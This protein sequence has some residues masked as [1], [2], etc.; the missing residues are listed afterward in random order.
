ML[1]TTH[2]Y[3][4]IE[5]G[6]GLLEVANGSFGDR[7]ALVFGK[8]GSG[9]I[10]EPTKPERVLLPEETLAVV[11]FGNIKSLDIVMSHLR[12]LREKMTKHEELLDGQR[13]EFK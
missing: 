13:S 3:P 11:T 8:N 2:T 4:L 9:V 7:Y 6:H 5:L 10:G 12:I 1:A